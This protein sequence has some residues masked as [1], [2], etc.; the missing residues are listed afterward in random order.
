MGGTMIEF[1][2]SARCASCAEIE[3]ALEEMVVAHRVV[4]VDPARPP[5]GWAGDIPLPALKDG[6]QTITGQ[7]AIVEHMKQLGQ[8]VEEWRRFQ[9]DACYCDE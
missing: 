4:V 1:Y 9:A 7:Q 3:E 8:F 5:E 6:G 2:R